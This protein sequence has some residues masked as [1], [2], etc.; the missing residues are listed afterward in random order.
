MIYRCTTHNISVSIEGNK[1]D[2]ETP[3]GSLRGM[4][5]C[6]LLTEKSPKPGKLGECEVE[7]VEE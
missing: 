7:K 5:Q 6:R 2:F 3:P 1:R 4:P